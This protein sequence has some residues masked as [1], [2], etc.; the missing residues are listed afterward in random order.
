MGTLTRSGFVISLLDKKEVVS[1]LTVRP[2]TNESVGIPA[3][4]F[5]VFRQVRQDL[6][7][8]VPKPA[9][10]LVPRYYALTK[11]GPP[12]KDVRH[13]YVRA[14]HLTFVGRLR[15]ATRQPEA[16]AA[17]CKA[18]EACGGGVLSLD[19][20][21]G[22]CLGKDTPV[23]MF[24]GSIKKVQDIHMGEFIMGDDSTPRKVLSTCTGT[25]QLYKIV[26]TKGD[27]YIVNESHILSLKRSKTSK[28]EDIELK[29]Y[30][31]LAST[32]KKRLKGYRVPISFPEKE[33]PLD[34]YM[35]GYWLGD[36][37]S[38]SARISCQD[39]TVLHYFHRNLGKYEL[40]LDYVSQYDYAI[41][42]KKPNYFFKTL[43]DL[44]LIK[45]KHIPQIYKC[46]SREVRLQVLAGLLD[47]D[48]SAI[49]GGW[50]FCQ[51]NE[52]LFD[53]VLFL[54]RSLGFACY[55]QKCTKTCT[56]AP[57]GPKTGTYF[58][59]S[60]SGAGNEE[61]PCKVPR[62]RVGAREQIKNVL[63]VGIKVEKLEV[64]E[65][66]GFEIDGNRRFVLGDFTVTHN[67]TV[68][69][70]LS[71]HLKV[72]T[73]IVVHKEFL[74]NQW[75]DRINEFCP[76]ATI[77][78]IQQGILDTDKDFVI[79][80]IQT[81]CSRGEDMIPP[82]TFDQF[83][84]LI[85]DE[86]HH[87][88]ASA[89]SQAMFRF[90]PKYTLGLTATPDRKDG[91]TRI[92]YWF[93]GPEFF[94]VQRTNQTTTKVECI[95]FKSELFKESPPV[96]RFGKL[97]MAEMIN[98]VT[99]MPDR[100]KV[101]CKLVRDALKGTRRVLILTDRRAHCHYFHQEFGLGLSGLYYGGLGEAD[102]TESSKKRVVIGTFSMAQEGLDIPVLDT[103][104][105]ASPKSDIVQAI[106]RIMRETPG[107]Q[108]DP[109]IYDIVDHWSVFH[110]MA[111][112]RANVYR[113]AGFEISSEGL[114]PP[115]PPSKTE[116]FG[117]GQCLL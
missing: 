87:I 90:C 105:L 71:A 31:D 81:L 69:L 47:S 64:G 66:F 62:K 9:A 76:S 110:A 97:N 35:I 27:S 53:D 115:E 57:G 39:S 52:T 44:N 91:L 99:D 8:K 72:R 109:L 36:G 23:L 56:N 4:S 103:V 74:A 73:L 70:A 98:I 42:G 45:N 84:L 13:D 83:G 34:P 22:K 116:V 117:K 50:D 5:K 101:I 68:A 20:G 63:N 17:G 11:F 38:A 96:S 108:N 32:R 55:K 112:K 7:S 6:D 104:I 18:F 107:K 77:G 79:A 65:Y 19:A 100:N 54:A 3:P 10:L 111:R 28:I 15:D 114:V 1:E 40:F 61:V 113:G 67:T 59:C 25:E 21:F 75:R 24:D 85:V 89:F 95:Q 92:L 60:I 58:R 46:N 12:A 93:L 29:D 102:L 49:K 51:K 2:L 16:F 41:M 26:P 48:G 94:R 43:R 88:G 82:K 14:P 106:G 33:V 30:L 37:M 78:R 80:M 86:A